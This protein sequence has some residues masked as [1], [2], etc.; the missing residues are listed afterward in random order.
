MGAALSHAPLYVAFG[1]FGATLVFFHAS[2]FALVAAFNRAQL[3]LDSLLLQR[4]YLLAMAIGAAEFALEA[5]MA[6]QGKALAVAR[7]FPLGLGAVMAGEALRKAAM[8]TARLGFTHLIQTRRRD[9]H[10]LCERGVYSWMGH[11]GYGGWTLWAVGTQLML[12]NP[13]CT[14]GFA[15]AAH[16]FFATRIPHEERTLASLFGEQWER[17]RARVRFSGVP[18]VP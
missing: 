14:L 3:S 7:C 11:P 10:E 2:E 4:P 16:R 18:G 1:S 6:P 12:A 15:A 13:L 9:G 8:L 17:Y 5:W